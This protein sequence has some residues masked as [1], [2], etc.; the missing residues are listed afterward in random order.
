MCPFKLL[1]EIINLVS[2]N[3]LLCFSG[4]GANLYTRSGK[5][6]SI[7]PSDTVQILDERD[8]TVLRVNPHSGTVVLRGVNATP[9]QRSFMRQSTAICVMPRLARI[10]ASWLMNQPQ[11]ASVSQRLL[12]SG[13]TQTTP[14]TNA[15]SILTKMRHP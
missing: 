5:I 4:A 6:A 10:P 9:N 14:V 13:R 11:T 12:E 3:L 15:A 1:S 7:S 8:Y 2:F